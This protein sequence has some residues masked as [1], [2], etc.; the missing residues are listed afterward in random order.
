[1]ITV[2]RNPKTSSYLEHKKIILS[3]TFPWFWQNKSQHESNVKEGYNFPFYSHIFLRR[4]DFNF[5]SIPIVNSEYAQPLA[6]I[7]FEILQFNNL[8]VNC[9]LRINANC[10]HPE[11]TILGTAPH[12]DHNFDHKNIIVY[13]TNA[14]GKTFVGDE[15]HD[16]KEDDVIIFGGETHYF[17]T[18]E[19][20][21]RVVLVATYI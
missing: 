6:T 17:Q 21:R 15:S 9:F 20:Q 1:M 12:V 5:S 14:G 19:N 3:D 11:K 4:P 2:I 8:E 18:P 10:V 16:P 13:L 7:L